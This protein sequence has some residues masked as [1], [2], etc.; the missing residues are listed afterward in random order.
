MA[1]NQYVAGS[2]MPIAHHTVLLPLC[3]MY[4]PEV[5]MHGNHDSDHL[6][7]IT[8]VIIPVEWDRQ[9]NVTSVS[10][11]AFDE[12]E[13]L[14]QKRVK[15]A[16]LIQHVRQDAEVVGWIEVEQGKKKITVKDYRLRKYPTGD[17]KW[18]RQET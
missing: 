10:I 18:A 9:G 12:Q 2:G 16:E 1:K 11:S 13:Y 4:K 7:T 6:A 14:V 3:G 5:D 17:V 15:G 8:G